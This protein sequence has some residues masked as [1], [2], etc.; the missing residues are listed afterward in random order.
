MKKDL[1]QNLFGQHI[2]NETILPA[3]FSH[4]KNMDKSQKP[5]VMSFHGTPGTGKNYMADR[6]VKHLYRNGDKSKY[7]HKFMGRIDFPLASKVDEYR[8]NYFG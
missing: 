1:E 5:L 7:V 6:I 2:A 4:Y 8:V 3:L